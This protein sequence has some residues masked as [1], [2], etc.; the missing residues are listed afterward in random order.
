MPALFPAPNITLAVHLIGR[1]DL[2]WHRCGPLVDGPHPVEFPD[3]GTR[4]VA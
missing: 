3:R 2:L 1:Y 4:G